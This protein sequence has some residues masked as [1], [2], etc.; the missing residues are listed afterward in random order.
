MTTHLVPEMARSNVELLRRRLEHRSGPPVTGR[1]LV[2]ACCH[3]ASALEELWG[4]LQ[5]TLKQG[6]SGVRL[7]GMLREYLEVVE[8]ALP[9]FEPAAKVA[10]DEGL[11]GHFPQIEGATAR[12][13]KVR[14]DMKA[15]L[16]WVSSP[17]PQVSA[18]DRKRFEEAAGPFER[19]SSVLRRLESE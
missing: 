14:D 16:S 2:F 10:Q 15:L 17:P 12:A 5:E 8:I 6:V 3:I 9:A 7:R 4:A 1:E 18:E 13:K 11:S 19:V